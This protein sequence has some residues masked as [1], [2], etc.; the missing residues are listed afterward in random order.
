LRRVSNPGGTPSI[1]GNIPITVPLNGNTIN[2][3]HL[4]NNNGTSGYLDGLDYRLLAAHIR[5]GRLWTAAN[6]AV[7]NTGAPNGT[8][9]RMGIRWYE[10]G[11][12]ATGQ[13]PAVL[14]SG[15][16]YQAS[17]GNTTDQRSYWMGTVM[18]SGQGHALMG[19]SSASVNDY[20]NAAYAY[21]LKSD[22]S[23]SFR[24][25]VLY[26][27][28]S[29]AY[30]PASNPGGS[31]GR[32]WGDY[33]YT[34]LD[35]DDDMTMWTIQEWCNAPG[36]YAVQVVKVLAPSPA[37]PVSCSPAS[38]N[39][40]TNNAVVTL[41][42]L[43]DGESGFFD[44]G[45]GFSNRLAIAISGTGV[46]VNSLT[47]NNPTNVTLNLSVAAG[48]AAGARTVTVINPDGQT[49]TSSNAILTITGVAVTNHPPV[50]PLIADKTVAEGNLLTFTNA[51]TDPD[52]NGMVYSLLNAPAGAA[53]TNNGV[54]TWTP[55][56]AQG[57]S[58][59]TIAMVVTDNGSPSL[60]ATQTF[61][62]FVLES[63][64]PPVL[65]AI[66]NYTI[67]AG[68][69]LVFTNAATDLDIPANSLQFS[70][71]A[72]APPAA[73]VNAGTGVF[74]WPTAAADADSTNSITVRV[75]D[76][77]LPALSDTKSFQVIVAAPLIIGSITAVSGDLEV[78]WPAIPGQ[79]YSLQ[80][81]TNLTPPVWLE[82][83]NF[84]ATG[85]SA[86]VTLP[87][88]S[89]DKKFYRLVVQP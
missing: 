22:V 75:T 3:P 13:T 31:G 14:Q 19:F 2:V 29:S 23:G 26:T 18:V 73:S 77:G 28:S 27:A 55:D 39:Q 6:I 54:F 62:V 5:N 57:P 65:A 72:G 30:N 79:A 74:T 49:A 17:A 50:L 69:A 41:I 82:L 56:E 66:S 58:T 24:A 25:P 46:T 11:N 59:N 53:V 76:N 88:G 20:A 60:S 86:A 78:T 7:D 63:N 4:G 38:L 16:I 64:Q 33:T 85:S 44:P 35:P 42:G 36:L 48:A 81:T 34:C 12:L 70:L 61:K 67:H 15:T 87:I 51:A 43:S 8:D 47:Y 68:T 21:R 32:R 1:S 40:G 80:A 10:L 84:T 37:A 89:A 71:D 9:T 83:T 52:D 45:N